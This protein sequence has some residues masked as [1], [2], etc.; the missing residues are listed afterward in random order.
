MPWCGAIRRARASVAGGVGG[1]SRILTS[2]WKAV[3]CTGRIRSELGGRPAGH[4]GDL[5][6]GVVEAG[7]EQVGDLGWPISALAAL[8]A[9]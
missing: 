7:D 4:R 1:R 8:A 3:K 5:G 2:G 6:V 9:C